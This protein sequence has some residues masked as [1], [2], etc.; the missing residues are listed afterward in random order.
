MWARVVWR[1]R[2]GRGCSG[3]F[4]QRLQRLDHETRERDCWPARAPRYRGRARGRRGCPPVTPP[5]APRGGRPA[6]TVRAAAG[7]G[8]GAAHVRLAAWQALDRAQLLGAVGKLRREG[9][10]G[11][12]G[13]GCGHWAARA[14]AAG[15]GR[16]GPPRGGQGMGA[17]GRAGGRGRGVR[18]PACCERHLALDAVAAR[19]LGRPVLAQLSLRAQRAFG[20]ESDWG[21]S[22]GAV[23]VGA[24]SVGTESVGTDL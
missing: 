17:G 24:E 20:A 21:G 19:A 1:G 15:R 13:A 10:R 7:D 6:R 14:A 5:C 9:G 3:G 2:A 11:G 23:R 12:R 22:V 16:I 18:W 4:K 8:K